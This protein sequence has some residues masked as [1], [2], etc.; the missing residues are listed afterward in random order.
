[1]KSIVV[2]C[3]VLFCDALFGKTSVVLSEPVSPG[4]ETSAVLALPLMS[5]NKPQ[6]LTISIEASN[7]TTNGLEIW[8]CNDASAS[9]ESRGYLIGF[10]EGRLIKGSNTVD[11]LEEQDEILPVGNVA[12]TTLARSRTNSLQPNVILSINGTPYAVDFQSSRLL[13]SVRVISR[14]LDSQ[15]PRLSESLVTIGFAIRIARL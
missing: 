7:V 8:F 15:L 11:S 10:D 4:M 14:G 5:G 12:F 6:R 2:L 3:V 13:R 9:R 1:M